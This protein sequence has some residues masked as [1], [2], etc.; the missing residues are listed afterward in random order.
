VER[1]YSGSADWAALDTKALGVLAVDAGAIALLITVHQDIN[2]LWWLPSV[3]LAAAGVLLIAAIW[4]REFVFGPDLLEFHDEMRR[5]SPL[6][7]AREM[8]DEFVAASR[9]NDD[10]LNMKTTLF[11]WSL[12]ILIVGLLGCLP[13]ALLR[14]D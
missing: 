5:G 14:P 13:I 2:R 8:L 11:W 1:F 7:A 9:Q 6:E 3:V 4:P 10:R 12:G